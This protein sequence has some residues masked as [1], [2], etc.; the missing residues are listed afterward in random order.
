[1]VSELDAGDRRII[2]CLREDGRMSHATIARRLDLAEATVRRRLQRMVEEG[3]LRLVPVVDPDSVG[4]ETS[5]FI[6]VKAEGAR[7][8]QV[9]DRVAAL[10]EV[11]YVAVTTGRFDLLVEAFVSH[12]EHMA[13]LLLEEI[14]QIKGVLSSEAMT[15]LRVAKFAYEWEVPDVPPRTRPPRPSK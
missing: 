1:L 8:Q 10:A 5:L 15:V 3:Q 12:R 13:V 6:G 4:L 9:T 11:R 2:E 14:G 7:L